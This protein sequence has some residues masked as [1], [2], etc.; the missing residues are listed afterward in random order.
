MLSTIFLFED[1][2]VCGKVVSHVS[3]HIYEQLMSIKLILSLVIA[4]P[5]DATVDF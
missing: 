1:I 5:Q 3:L 4:G 2:T